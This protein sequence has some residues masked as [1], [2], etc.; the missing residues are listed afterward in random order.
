MFASPE[1]LACCKCFVTILWWCLSVPIAHRKIIYF[2]IF[3]LRILFWDV[4]ISQK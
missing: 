4:N 2:Y 1:M 3:F